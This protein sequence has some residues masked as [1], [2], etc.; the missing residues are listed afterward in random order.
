MKNFLVM[1]Y[2]KV[3]RNKILFG[4]VEMIIVVAGKRASIGK[5]ELICKLG[6][7]L[8]DV[9]AVKCSLSH[10]VNAPQIITDLKILMSNG[11]DT[12]KYLEAGISKA[13]LI[14][15]NRKDLSLVVKELEHLFNQYRYIFIEGNTIVAFLSPDMVIYIEDESEDRTEG[16]YIS[17]RI[18]DFKIRAFDYSYQDILKEIKSL[19]PTL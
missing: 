19:K 15:S 12:A 10:E 5:T 6:S 13:I 7:Y 11:K 2:S 4:N 16:S 14:R 9:L 8:K 17:E 1:I 3:R 18:A